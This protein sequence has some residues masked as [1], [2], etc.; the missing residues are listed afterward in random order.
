[1]KSINRVLECWKEWIK[2]SESQ[3]DNG[4]IFKF[5]A[6]FTKTDNEKKHKI[7]KCR[8][9]MDKDANI[10]IQRLFKNKNNAKAWNALKFYSSDTNRNIKQIFPKSD[11]IL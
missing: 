2:S 3:E 8:Y 5:P 11:N 1:M 7:E 4:K 6:E 9:N 10:I